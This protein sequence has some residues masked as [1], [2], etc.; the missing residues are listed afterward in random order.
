MSSKLR[1]L[2]ARFVL[3]A[4]LLAITASAC[5]LTDGI[6]PTFT[7]TRTAQPTETSSPVPERPPIPSPTATL[8]PIRDCNGG[9]ALEHPLN[10][11]TITPSPKPRPWC[12]RLRTATV[13]AEPTYRVCNSTT[14]TATPTPSPVP[15][16]PTSTPPPTRDTRPTLTPTPTVT[17]QPT[18]IPTP[19]STPT[20]SPLEVSAALLDQSGICNTPGPPITF[21]AR[22]DFPE[23]DWAP[24]PSWRVAAAATHNA[25]N[26]EWDVLD[27]PEVTEYRVFRW[28]VDTD[29]IE[30]VDRDPT[31]TS[32]LDTDGIFPETEYRYWVFPIKSG[33]LGKPSDPVDVVTPASYLPAIPRALHGVGSPKSVGLVWTQPKDETIENFTVFRRDFTSNTNWMTVTNEVPLTSRDERQKTKGFNYIDGAGL[34]PGNE[35]HYAVCAN[36]PAGVGA[37][38]DIVAVEIAGALEISAPENVRTDAKYQTLTLKWDAVAHPAVAGYEVLRR[39]PKSEDYYRV[40]QRT[41]SRLSTAIVE[42][43]YV[44]RRPT[45]YQYKVRAFVG[46]SYVDQR[47]TDSRHGLRA[48]TPLWKGEESE[49]ISVTTVAAPIAHTD[50]P[51]VPKNLT[52]RA[53]HN[54]VSLEWD[55]VADP[56]VTSYRIFRK[57]IG[58]DEQYQ[59]HEL[60]N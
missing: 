43:S 2:N 25:V 4:L 9:G 57:E 16:T 36:A 15:T 1:N 12:P 29:E 18:F 31:V 33:I 5:Q 52:A 3:L 7:P 51:Q 42:A 50:L 13:V 41:G 30:V 35:Y 24:P 28:Q 39:V 34:V 14:A 20:P 27:E 58:V 17:P 19:T 11:D 53:T 56:M 40:V 49:S 38:S 23:R 10:R 22:P 21:I 48:V 26:L 32:F 6:G 37:A 45:E 54:Y 44:D 60:W 8:T 59:V 47:P 46:A 55:P